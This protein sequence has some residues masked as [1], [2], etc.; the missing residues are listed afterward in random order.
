MSRWQV[1]GER[2]VYTSD[3]VNVHLADVELPDGSRF[4]HHALR[5]ARPAVAV[6][7]SDAARGV[8]M[9][10]RHRFIT[11]RWGWE[12]PAGR[13]EAGEDPIQAGVRECLEETG[14]RPLE[15]QLIGAYAP[16]H[17]LSDMIHH[18]VLAP[19]A[20]QAGDPQDTHEASEIAWVAVRRILPMVTG[21]EMPDG[22]SQHALLLALALG[23]VR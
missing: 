20:E 10:R 7:V 22:Y 13:I 15:P 11:D 2:A 14:W 18:V 21:G 19:A 23:S 1:H 16:M 5:M 4:E 12:V 6:V 9:L 17:G 3:W 8:L